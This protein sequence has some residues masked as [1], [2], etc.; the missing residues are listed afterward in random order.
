M[1]KLENEVL[2]EEWLNINKQ[3]AHRETLKNQ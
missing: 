2:N 3:T 1:Y